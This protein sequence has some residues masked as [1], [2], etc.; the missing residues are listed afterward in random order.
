MIIYDAEDDEEDSMNEAVSSPIRLWK[1]SGNKVIIPFTVPQRL[2][3][4]QRNEI[5][6]AIAEFHAKTCIR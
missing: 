3:D 6:K 5:D 1:K 2:S 4:H